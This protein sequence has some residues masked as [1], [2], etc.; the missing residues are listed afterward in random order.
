MHDDYDI[1]AINQIFKDNGYEIWG[2]NKSF[3]LSTLW[4]EENGEEKI[5]LLVK[6][7]IIKED[8]VL[9]LI[10]FL[11]DTSNIGLTYE[12]CPLVRILEGLERDGTLIYEDSEHIHYHCYDVNVDLIKTIVKL[13]GHIDQNKLLEQTF[14]DG[15]REY[16]VFNYLIDNFTFNK[17]SIVNTAANIVGTSDLLSTDKGQKAL[18][19]L[20]EIGLDIN[21]SFD[22]GFNFDYLG[23]YLGLVFS[24]NIE[25]FNQYLDKKP[26]QH[27][28]DQFLWEY[29]TPESEM[30]EEH[31]VV[32]SR[33]LKM[34]Y[35]LPL[36]EIVNYLNKYEYFDI[37]TQIKALA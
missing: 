35:Q 36:T 7:K 25:L 18:K 13:G 26:E 5:R 29:V 8:E 14:F 6:H 32:I 24:K 33:M 3:S 2:Q 30:N 19:C 16:W 4:K 37:A 34:G 17:K 20:T 27:I 10:F 22:E 11:L 15:K 12:D 28:I 1:E 21:A 23:S 9:D 31:V